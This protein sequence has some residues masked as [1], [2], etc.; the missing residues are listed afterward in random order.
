MY[1]KD[2]EKPDLTARILKNLESK[3]VL[4]T[5]KRTEMHCA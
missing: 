3:E 2:S 4:G 1:V 5:L